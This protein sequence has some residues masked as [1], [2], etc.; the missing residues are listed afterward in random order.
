MSAAEGRR[1]GRRARRE[2]RTAT[3]VISLPTL[4]REIPAY[5]ILDEDKLELVHD[6]SM[7]ILEEVGI[8]FRDDE[9]LAIWKAAGA[10]VD[11]ERV[12]I[13][14]DQLME[15][16]AKAPSDFTMHARNPDRTVEIG[17]RNM[18]FAPT[19]GSPYV[20][21][22]NNERR[23]S[24]LEDLNN[25]HKLAYLTPSLHNTGAIICEPV[26]IAVSKRHLHT[27]YSAIKYSDKSFMGATTAR[28][29]AEDTV[30]MAKIVFGEDYLQDHTVM[31]SVINC[32]SPLVWD[33]TMLDAL[34]VYAANNQ[35]VL[36]SPFVLAGA[37]T[38]ASTWPSPSA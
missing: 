35:S 14:R 4:V 22:F 15:L 13:S 5:E 16:I 8:D 33:A 31:T 32:N 2:L 18:I 29:R 3:P 12:R 36:C 9:A 21:D 25:F 10:D 34:K 30:E 37:S 7:R 27:A 20:V 38:S 24:T 17:G 23:Y 26:D 1:G 11:E 28:E 19:Y 6:A